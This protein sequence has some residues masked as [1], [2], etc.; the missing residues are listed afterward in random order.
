M[1]SLT[2]KNIPEDIYEQLKK[3]AAANR[4]SINSEVITIIDQALSNRRL[5][6]DEWLPE[7]RRIREKTAGYFITEKELDEAKRAGRA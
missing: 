6:P 5:D 7:A 2:I 3:S 1:V 4:R